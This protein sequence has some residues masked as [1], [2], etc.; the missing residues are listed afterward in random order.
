MGA[1]KV[2][3][4]L[5]HAAI[6]VAL[7][8]FSGTA[9]AMP[10]TVAGTLTGDPGD[11]VELAL[12]DANVVD[13]EAASIKISFDP[14][15]LTLTDVLTGDVTSG[16]WLVVGTPSGGSPSEVL[17]SLASSLDP[18]TGIS[19]SLLVAKF[20][21]KGSAPLGQTPVVFESYDTDYEVPATTGIVTISSAS[22]PEAGT[23]PLLMLGLAGLGAAAVRRRLQDQEPS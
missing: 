17:V 8:C 12:V 6:A 19:G 11:S 23:A 10:F 22:M 13:L 9:S 7:V 4:R 2:M 14:L 1:L 3:P 16:F 18:L 15:S 5:R 21:I 20:D